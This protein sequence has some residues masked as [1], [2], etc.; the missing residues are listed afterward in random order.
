MADDCLGVVALIRLRT[1]YR[2]PPE[3]VY[4]YRTRMPPENARRLFMEYIK[5]MNKLRDK[6]Q[7]Y[8][9]LTTNCT[10]NIVHHFRAFG[11]TV[12]YNWKILLS[13]YTPLYAYEIG[14][15]DDTFPFEELRSKSY[16]NPRARDIGDAPDFSKRI[17]AGLPGMP[18]PRAEPGG[19]AASRLPA[20]FRPHGRAEA[21][22]RDGV[23][24]SAQA[25]HD[26]GGRMP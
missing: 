6:P 19:G 25:P 12:R 9:T 21:G 1:D 11:D 10:T 7:F 15:L 8:N 5:E 14:G 26:A 13:G 3:D 20:A 18:G 4:L 23:A 16:V 24:A 2:R 17:R 22:L